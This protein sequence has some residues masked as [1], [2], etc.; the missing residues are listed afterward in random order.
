MK[1]TQSFVGYDRAGFDMHGRDRAGYD[2]WGID[3]TGHD[4]EGRS[5]YPIDPAG[6]SYEMMERARGSGALGGAG[7]RALLDLVSLTK[8]TTGGH[9]ALFYA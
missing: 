1:K 7:R 9:L 5:I 2:F 8:L 6:V 4:R 3:A